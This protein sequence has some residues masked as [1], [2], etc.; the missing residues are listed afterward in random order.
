M[1][2][3]SLHALDHADQDLFLVEDRTLL[4]MQLEEGVRLQRAGLR[5]PEVTD[6]AQLVA[7]CDA[8]LRS[9]NT[10]GYEVVGL[11]ARIRAARVAMVNDTPVPHPVKPYQPPPPPPED[12]PPPPPTPPPTEDT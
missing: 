9:L 1:L 7:D 2:F 10:V 3:R 4:D 5:G 6:A 8:V 11:A 12:P